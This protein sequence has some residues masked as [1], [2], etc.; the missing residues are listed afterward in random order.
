MNYNELISSLRA[1]SPTEYET[2]ARILIQSFADVELSAALSN[3]EAELGGGDRLPRA[4]ARRLE[5]EPLQYIIGTWEFYRQEYEVD[6]SCLIPRADTELLV[7]RAIELLPQGAHILDLC[8]GSG[9]IAISTLAER[10]DVSAVMVDK[11][12]DT[13][14]LAKRNAV[15]NGVSER[16][17]AI[18]LDVFDEGDELSGER[19][20]AILSNPPYIRPEVIET[21]SPEVRREPYAA[22]YG[23]EDGLIFYRRIVSHYSRNLKNGGF[24]LFEIGYDQASDLEKIASR[25]GFSCKIFKDYGGNDRVALLKREKED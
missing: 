12:E 9:C 1:I 11:F 7:E 25:H 8:T 21:L 5:H 6:S 20:D 19:F 10:A 17:K 15:R 2:E 16:V 22:L 24:F 23:G 4:L 18:R 14:A 3:R 13:L